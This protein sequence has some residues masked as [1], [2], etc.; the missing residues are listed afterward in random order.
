L[1]FEKNHPFGDKH[2]PHD[3]EKNGPEDEF[4]VDGGV[5]DVAEFKQRKEF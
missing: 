5:N 4:E 3:S 1:P 2:L